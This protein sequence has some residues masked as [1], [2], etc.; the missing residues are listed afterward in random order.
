MEEVILFLKRIYV[1]SFIIM[2]V[3]LLSYSY[4]DK[5]LE[6]NSN[7]K[8]NINL[9][10]NYIITSA[11][12]IINTFAIILMIQEDIKLFKESRRN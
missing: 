3:Y 8:P 6:L 7:F 10:I 2:W 11:S 5:Y 9:T 4:I 12:P 1:L